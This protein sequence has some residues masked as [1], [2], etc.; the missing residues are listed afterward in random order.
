MDKELKITFRKH[1]IDKMIKIINRFDEESVDFDLGFEVSVLITSIS[2]GI[3]DYIRR[4]NLRDVHIGIFSND[5][6]RIN[7]CSECVKMHYEAFGDAYRQTIVSLVQRFYEGDYG[8]MY[9]SFL[10][11]Q[12]NYENDRM[13]RTLKG[14]YDTMYGEIYISMNTLGLTS[15]C[16]NFERQIGN[17]INRFNSTL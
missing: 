6:Y 4:N 10:G 8:D 16:H 15:T 3:E 5:T 13:S 12:G 2:K 9:T 17:S 14:L 11:K 1:E 7:T